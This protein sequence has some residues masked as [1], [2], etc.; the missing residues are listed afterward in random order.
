MY[1][2]TVQVNSINR[3]NKK[4]KMGKCT[5]VLSKLEDGKT[6]E[7]WYSFV[8][9]KRKTTKS[10]GYLK[11]K[12]SYTSA[13]VCT[14]FSALVISPFINTS[15]QTRNKDYMMAKENYDQIATVS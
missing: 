1:D 4:K 3:L 8:K 2:L 14:S 12:V 13:V 10:K 9:K 5:V 6:L 11:I 15:F 7:Q